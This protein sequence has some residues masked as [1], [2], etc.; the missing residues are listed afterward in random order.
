MLRPLPTPHLLP[1]YRPLQQI[2]RP[3]WPTGEAPS[4]SEA[5][6]SVAEL[7][8]LIIEIGSMLSYFKSGILIVLVSII[9]EVQVHQLKWTYE[10]VYLAFRISI[11]VVFRAYAVQKLERSWTKLHLLHTEKTS[12]A[13]CM[14]WLISYGKSI[15]SVQ[16]LLFIYFYL[17]SRRKR[18]LATRTWFVFR[19]NFETF[20]HCIHAV[21]SVAERT[22][23]NS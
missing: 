2:T 8:S 12:D 23:N 1:A 19:N 15:M 5:P 13:F 20:F 7:G 10:V 21:S 14:W 6:P 18:P 16:H 9:C 17:Q 22:S 11:R 4:P 3:C